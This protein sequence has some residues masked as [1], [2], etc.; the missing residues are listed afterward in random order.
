MYAYNKGMRP[1]GPAHKH[2]TWSKFDK[3]HFMDYPEKTLPSW[4][5]KWAWERGPRGSNK[6]DTRLPQL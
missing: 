2:T 1:V 3:L 5:Y 4:Q 6:Q